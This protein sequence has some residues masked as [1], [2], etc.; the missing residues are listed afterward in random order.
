MVEHREDPN[1]KKV[2][3][4]GNGCTRYYKPGKHDL[5]YHELGELA[6]KRSLRDAGVKFE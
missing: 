1:R 4:I 6:I 3:V 2:F 5:D